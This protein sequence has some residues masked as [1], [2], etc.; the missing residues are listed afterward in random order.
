MS[1]RHA[2]PDDWVD[3]EYDDDEYVDEYGEY[4]RVRPEASTGSRWRSSAA[5]R[6]T[7]PS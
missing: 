3:D 2:N 4:E 6:E 7:T 1:P 5:P